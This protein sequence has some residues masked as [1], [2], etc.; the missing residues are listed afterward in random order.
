ME[1]A[2]DWRINNDM[3]I[4]VTVEVSILRK[5]QSYQLTIPTSSFH[6]QE[7]KTGN[8]VADVKGKPE[9]KFTFTS[10]EPGELDPSHTVGC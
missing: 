5:Y 8:V 1:D 10:H 9:G 6:A 2:K 7:V 3:G 4:Q